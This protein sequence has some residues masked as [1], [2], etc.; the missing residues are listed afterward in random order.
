MERA[1]EKVRQIGSMVLIISCL[2][3]QGFSFQNSRNDELYK[4]ITFI[5]SKDE[6]IASSLE[7]RVFEDGTKTQNHLFI[8]IRH[9]PG[10]FETIDDKTSAYREMTLVDLRI[11][12]AED[13]FE[14][15]GSFA[16]DIENNKVWFIG[17][18]EYELT[19][20]INWKDTVTFSRRKQRRVI[21]YLKKSTEVKTH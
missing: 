13:Y 18:S 4:R 5:L 20:K 6:R 19:Y 3:L 9:R 2:H 16:V 14:L 15:L 12:I 11:E 8:T 10:Q 17:I 1:L 21:C 7:H